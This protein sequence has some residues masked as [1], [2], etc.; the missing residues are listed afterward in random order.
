MNYC[1]DCKDTLVDPVEWKY[2]YC[3]LCLSIH[4]EKLDEALTELYWDFDE[5][6]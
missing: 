4:L 6:V 2:G 5:G 3:L 1:R